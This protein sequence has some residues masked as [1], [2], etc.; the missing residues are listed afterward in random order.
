M[1]K[2]LLLTASMGTGHV[3]A[4]RSVLSAIKKFHH[5]EIQSE[6]IDFVKTG[7]LLTKTAKFYYEKSIEY[8]PFIWQFTYN[9]TNS[10]YLTEKTTFFSKFVYPPQAPF[11]E[12]KNADIFL[13]THPCW[14]P[15][16]E[17]LRNKYHNKN[18]IIT[19]IT[20]SIS[21]H[22]S[23]ISPITDYYIVANENTATVVRSYNISPEKIKILG[24]PVSLSF[25]D[26][27]FELSKK[28]FLL[29]LGLNLDKLVFLFVLGLGNNNQLL[30]TIEY[31]GKKDTLPFQ[32][33][34]IC[35][36]YKE[37]Y[38]RLSAKKFPT[39]IKIVSWITNM[40]DYLKASDIVITK[41]G[42]A[43][44]ME[45][46]AAVKPIVITRIIPGQEEG[47]AELVIKYKLGFI[48]TSPKTIINLIMELVSSP[49]KLN[50]YQTNVK[51]FLIPASAEKI[52]DFIFELSQ[53]K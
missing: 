32:I 34:V 4:S 42:G 38:R 50:R 44:L 51:N 11:L 17:A 10:Y 36:R 7:N 22:S 25:A 15:T 35:G 19:L 24:F 5:K 16:L 13:T 12:A 6:L 49:D 28:E 46:L 18:K 47:N 29:S 53:I 9:S 30:K 40:P 1:K 37:I 45:T 43:I 33:I 31:F 48:R 20:D 39:E 27:F 14:Y 21:I 3:S 26:S 52:S 8:F 2:I 23:W 41:A